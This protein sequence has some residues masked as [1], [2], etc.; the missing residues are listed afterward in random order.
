MADVP[1]GEP[2]RRLDR[3]P[4]LRQSVQESIM[5][6]VVHG[7]L[8]PGDPLKPETELARELGVS[9]NSVRE[10]VKGLESVGVLETRRGT[11]LFLREFSF[12][13]LVDNLPYGLMSDVQ[14]LAELLEIRRILETG[15]I[16]AVAKHRTE[17]QVQQLKQVLDDMRSRAEMGQ[18]FP[19]EDREFH[20]LLFSQVGNKTLLKL[21]DVF[22]LGFK[23]AAEHVNLIDEDPLRTYRSHAEI[24]ES[25]IAEDSEGA[26]TALDRH[27]MW[28]T[29][30]LRKAQNSI[31]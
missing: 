12:D 24:V 21:L 17:E 28:V 31:Q 5:D 25:L 15:M 10:A 27:Y 29:E 30:R 6:Y 7:G 16:D 9:R 8:Q 13:S 4:S 19:Q 11:G 14:D 23:K 3:S 26:R 2:L 1:R 22:W 20:R 18:S